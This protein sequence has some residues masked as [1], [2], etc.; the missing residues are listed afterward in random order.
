MNRVRSAATPKS[1]FVSFRFVLL[2]LLAVL[3]LST[4]AAHAESANAFYKRG[5]AAEQSEDYDAAFENF[6]KAAVIA[7]KD[8]R[9]REALYRVR[10][11]ASG[12]H[13]TKGRKLVVAG[14]LQAMDFDVAPVVFGCAVAA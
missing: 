4:A 9:I 6:Q 10:I 12:L 11:S 13:V 8:L 1:A 7:P 3:A 14:D 2:L 5:V